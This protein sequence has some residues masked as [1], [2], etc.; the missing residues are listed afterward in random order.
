VENKLNQVPQIKA[1]ISSTTEDLYQ[2]RNTA[3]EV[4]EEIS[5]EI[6]NEMSLL[7]DSMDTN[8]PT[9]ED[10]TPISTCKGWVEDADWVVLIIAFHYGHISDEEEAKGLSITELEYEHAKFLGKRVFVFIAG[11]PRSH[12]A[13]RTTI[14]ER[15][16][17]K[18][19]LGSPNQEKLTT[20]KQKLQEEQF[21][22]NFQN[23]KDFR[24]KLEILL[25]T[26]CR[27]F[28]NETYGKNATI[29]TRKDPSGS[30]AKL[31]LN[32]KKSSKECNLQV[33]DLLTYKE[34]H[35]NLHDVRQLIIRPLREEFIPGWDE[36]F[37]KLEKHSSEYEIEIDS[38][39]I[40][41]LRW[42]KK[43]MQKHIRRMNGTNNSTKKQEDKRLIKF[44]EDIIKIEL[45]PTPKIKK[46]S[47]EEYKEFKNR[48]RKFSIFVQAAFQQSN[49]LMLQQG[50]LLADFKSGIDDAINTYQ[51]KYEFTPEQRDLIKPRINNIE[52]HR[53][54]LI[55]ALNTHN[56]WQK[57][58]DEFEKIDNEKDTD[59]DEYNESLN[60]FCIVNDVE[61]INE[62][63]CYLESLESEQSSSP[64]KK[65]LL[66]LQENWTKMIDSVENYENIRKKFDDVFYSVDKRT[67][68]KV[69]E[70]KS[71]VDELEK[72]FEQSLEQYHQAQQQV[73]NL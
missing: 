23:L 68:R 46:I 24:D 7:W 59:L 62:E 3:S 12:D 44:L 4:I 21:F 36:S 6:Q 72:G 38:S 53:E 5:K 10:K 50:R 16:D 30:F 37:I 18:D 69:D 20:F 47:P 15:E 35:D 27:D 26:N 67:L 66:F 17:L 63:L 1:M 43:A 58:H 42:P 33:T 14:G 57:Y 32:I 8:S 49:S 11:T 41:D 61:I 65:V 39:L 29:K 60:L 51:E 64:I 70:A 73:N 19:W 31:L 48:L 22:K 45:L 13:Y 25:R 55:T 34:V 56:K 71:C 28:I 40:D 2:Y 52:I 9:G 54:Q